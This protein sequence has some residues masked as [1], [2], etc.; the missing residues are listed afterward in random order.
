MIGNISLLLTGK[1]PAIYSVIYTDP[2]GRQSYF[3]HRVQTVRGYHPHDHLLAPWLR[4]VGLCHS[5]WA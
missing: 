1:A 5:A 2:F 3:Q 4:L